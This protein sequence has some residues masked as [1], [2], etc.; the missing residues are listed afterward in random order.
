M[1]GLPHTLR[2]ERDG[3]VANRGIDARCGEM[4]GCG[5]DGSVGVCRLENDV[6][7]LHAA[8]VGGVEVDLSVGVEDLDAA[9]HEVVVADEQG[10][11]WR[12]SVE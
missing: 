5:S 12:L 7:L 2:G 9:A 3:P 10:A 1:A 8:E 11:R 6:W 4:E